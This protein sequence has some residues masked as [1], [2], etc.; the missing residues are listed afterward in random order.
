MK[1][2]KLSTN[3][4]IGIA[5]GVTAV[6]SLFV[7]KAVLAKPSTPK[8]PQPSTPSTPKLPQ[9]STPLSNNFAAMNVYTVLDKAAKYETDVG[10]L[11]D[12][13]DKVLAV[14]MIDRSFDP[15][16]LKL[17]ERLDSLLPFMERSYVRSPSEPM[18][19][20]STAWRR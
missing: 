15:Y 9:S 17:R 5:V 1:K 19:P 20:I 11:S 10:I 18:E 7:A 13:V 12:L 14:S 16:W 4:K 6:A 2:K 3:A 8:L